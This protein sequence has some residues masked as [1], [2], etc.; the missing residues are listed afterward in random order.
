MHKIQQKVNLS[1]HDGFFNCMSF[2]VYQIER[3]MEGCLVFKLSTELHNSGSRE[4]WSSYKSIIL[5]SLTSDNGS[6]SDCCTLNL[7][8]CL[9]CHFLHSS[10]DM[11]LLLSRNSC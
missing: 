10:S 6:Q 4:G 7:I 1:R 5:G 2:A 9:L 8:S 3:G 11:L